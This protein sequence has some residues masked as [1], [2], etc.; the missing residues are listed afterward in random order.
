LVVVKYA[1]TENTQR[2]ASVLGEQRPAPRALVRFAARLGLLKHGQSL[3]SQTRA[4]G[5][6]LVYGGAENYVPCPTGINPRLWLAELV[7]SRRAFEQQERRASRPLQPRLRIIRPKQLHR[8]GRQG[9]RHVRRVRAIRS[10]RRTRAGPAQPDDPDPA[11]PRSRRLLE[12]ALGPVP[13]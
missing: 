13:G 10:A 11:A 8:R 3:R 6:C 1:T 4:F 12:I 9:T 2:E 7:P 5:W